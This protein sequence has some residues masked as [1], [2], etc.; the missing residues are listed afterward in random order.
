MT[1]IFRPLTFREAKRA[2]VPQ[3]VALLVDDV[4]GQ[5]RELADIAPYLAAFDVMQSEGGNLLIVGVDDQGIVGATY[6]LTFIS[7][8]SLS[9]ARRAQIESVR[10]ASHLRGQ[11]IG[12]Q[13][14]NDAEARARAAGCR[15]LQLTM[16][17][18]RTDTHRFYERLGFTPSHIGFKRY[19]N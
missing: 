19:L 14:I 8:L 2:E 4:L 9:A 10:V 16:N 5:G 1:R 3:V 18:N 11:G 17:Q 6:Q 15:L 12:A 7:G 13:L